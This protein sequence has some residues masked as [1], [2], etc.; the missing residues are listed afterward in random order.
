[1]S[2]RT[3]GALHWHANT[4]PAQISRHRWTGGQTDWMNLSAA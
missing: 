3:S 1:M 2:V 4:S